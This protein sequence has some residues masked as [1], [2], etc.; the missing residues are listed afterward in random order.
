MGNEEIGLCG[1]TC[2]VTGVVR[3]MLELSCGGGINRSGLELSG[4]SRGHLTCCLRIYFGRGQGA[5]QLFLEQTRVYP[6]GGMDRNS[7][8]EV[9]SG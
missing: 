7:V 5:V 9:V 2:G 4:G 1:G 8:V 6:S 3:S